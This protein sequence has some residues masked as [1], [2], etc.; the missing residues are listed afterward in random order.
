MDI[1]FHNEV[2]T[3]EQVRECIKLLGDEYLDL[4][5]QVIIYKDVAEVQKEWENEPNMIDRSYEDVIYH[6]D[7]A[8]PG[9]CTGN[10][11]MIRIYPFNIGVSEISELQELKFGLI[12]Y[13]FH[14]I[15]H[16]Y[17]YQHELFKD[18][19]IYHPSGEDMVNYANSPAEKDAYKFAED[20]VTDPFINSKIKE[21]LEI[22]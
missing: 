13:L 5:F 7:T 4:P 21:I 9:I 8:P 15:R 3:H 10:P 16:A 2:I 22:D 17:Q 1:I 20:K 14:E 6:P 18:D 11:K 19:T 12:Y